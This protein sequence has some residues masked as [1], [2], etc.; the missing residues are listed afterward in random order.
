MVPLD[1]GTENDPY[2]DRTMFSF[3]LH[4]HRLDSVG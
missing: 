2:L 3:W 1:F 4:F